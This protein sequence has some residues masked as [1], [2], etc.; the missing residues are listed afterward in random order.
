M[1]DAT[2]I[3]QVAAPSAVAL[4][5][6]WFSSR[7]QVR[8]FRHDLQLADRAELRGLLDEATRALTSMGGRSHAIQAEL[9]THGE[10]IASAAEPLLDAFKNQARAIEVNH[11][12][13]SIRVGPDA[14][15]VRW[16]LAARD[17]ARDIADAVALLSGLGAQPLMKSWE[18]I[19]RAT[20]D[21]ET[22]R[23]AFVRE[24][25]ARIG[26]AE[27]RRPLLRV[28]LVRRP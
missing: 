9:M 28:R 14:A 8:G 18:T 11:D 25:V 6:I 5:A 3:V 21:I 2:A 17:A 7:Q 1:A 20:A 19:S 15:L 24:A 26:V 16:H 22:A 4:A 10:N 27:A 13:L 12:R 23:E